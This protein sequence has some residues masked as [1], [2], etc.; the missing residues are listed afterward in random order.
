M[1]RSSSPK[2]DSFVEKMN[3]LG[4]IIDLAWSPVEVIEKVLNISK[5]PIVISHMSKERLSSING[6]LKHLVSIVYFNHIW[7]GD[8]LRR[9]LVTERKKRSFAHS[10]TFGWKR[11]SSKT[12]G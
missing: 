7:S 11:K 6:T 4:L 8:W 3:Q 2:L 12:D 1:S 10:I 5:A 9:F